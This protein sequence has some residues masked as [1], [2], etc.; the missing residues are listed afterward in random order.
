MGSLV[1]ALAAGMVATFNPCGFAMLPAYLAMF[2]GVEEDQPDRPALLTGLRV[3]ALVTAGFVVLFSA[4]GLAVAAGLQSLRAYL[5]WMA[6]VIGIGLFAL[7]FAVLRGRHV[8]IR[9]IDIKTSS[10]AGAGAMFGFGVAY[11][12]A[13][14]SCTLPIFLAVAGQALSAGSI[15]QAWSLFVAYALGMGIVLT[16]LAITLVTSRRVLVDRMRTILPYV[17]RIGGWLLVVSGLYIVYY[18]AVSLAIP[19]GSSSVLLVPLRFVETISGRLT[20]IVG[21]EPLLWVVVLVL[22]AVAIG[23]FELHRA[24]THRTE[25][26]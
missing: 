4:V 3:G 5:P 20:G 17:E 18:W 11:G 19:P 9:T 8:G 1:F 7:G 25:T 15:A 10:R 26:V 13:S 22:A 21:D 16:A 24:R 6:I 12:I 23:A 14:V 2:L